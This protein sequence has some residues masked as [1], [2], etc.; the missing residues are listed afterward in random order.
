[1]NVADYIVGGMYSK[2]LA[3]PIFWLR[4]G[5]ALVAAYVAALPVHDALVKCELK[6]CYKGN[7]RLNYAWDKHWNK[8]GLSEANGIRKASIYPTRRPSSRL[9][10]TDLPG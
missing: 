9:F 6:H 4:H 5:A 3:S 8:P 1:M 7:A 10:R 2:S